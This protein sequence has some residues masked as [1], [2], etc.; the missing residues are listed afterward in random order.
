MPAIAAS[1]APSTITAGAW[2]AAR[3]ALGVPPAAP[4]G[5]MDMACKGE[6][7]GALAHGSACASCEILHPSHPSRTSL[8]ASKFL[9]SSTSASA[10][11]ACAMEWRRGA[12]QVNELSSWAPQ[13]PA[14]LRHGSPLQCPPHRTAP[15]P[16]GAAACAP[17][18]ACEQPGAPA[19]GSTARAGR[20]RHSPV[21]AHARHPWTQP[22]P[23]SHPCPPCPSHGQH[24]L[25]PAGCAPWPPA[26]L[27]RRLARAR[28]GCSPKRQAH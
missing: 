4:G 19:Q 18:P 8:A 21:A 23:S 1:P 15:R 10:L 12:T 24:S 2:T 7:C 26:W 16:G 28:P 27:W 6:W 17:P 14:C 11:C 22:L 3:P 20:V 25:A 13:A 9:P 5:R